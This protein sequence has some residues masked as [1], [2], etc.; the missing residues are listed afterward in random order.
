MAFIAASASPLI[1]FTERGITLTQLIHCHTDPA[2]K[3]VSSDLLTVSAAPL[4]TRDRSH[5]SRGCYTPCLVQLPL[6]Q[7]IEGE[8][9]PVP[10]ALLFPHIQLRQETAPQLRNLLYA[11]ISHSIPGDHASA[12][13]KRRLGAT[14][15]HYLGHF[16][17]PRGMVSGLICCPAANNC[18]K[19]AGGSTGLPGHTC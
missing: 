4:H 2:S 11:K 9:L 10:L 16:S 19:A 13:G 6:R 1:N 15:A 18:L 5:C 14:T 17:Q 7:P 3:L 8:N 12:G